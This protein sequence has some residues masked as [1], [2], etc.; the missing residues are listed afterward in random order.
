VKLLYIAGIADSD[1]Q[2]LKTSSGSGENIDINLSV[3]EKNSHE[4]AKTIE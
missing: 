3:Q 1:A 4:E 2:S